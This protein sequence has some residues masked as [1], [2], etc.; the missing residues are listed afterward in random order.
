M[1]PLSQGSQAFFAHPEGYAI[2]QALMRRGVIGD[3][4]NPDVL[5]L[6]AAPLYFPY[7][8]IYDAVGHLRQVMDRRER[9]DEGLKLSTAVT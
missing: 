8:D 6:G 5:R 9:D 7:G 4:R 3:F 2:T 1:E